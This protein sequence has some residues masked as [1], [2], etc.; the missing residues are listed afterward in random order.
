MAYA[1]RTR[2]TPSNLGQGHSG[3]GGGPRGW[4]PRGLRQLTGGPRWTG[5]KSP[6][7]PRNQTQP[8]LRTQSTAGPTINCPTEN[9]LA[10]RG[11]S[12]DR[13]HG[14]Q[15]GPP[16]LECSWGTMLL[17]NRGPNWQLANMSACWLAN[18]AANLSA[19][20]GA[21]WGSKWFAASWLK[22]P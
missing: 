12:S 7:K 18:P 15:Q 6:Q 19:N 9:G 4:I 11:H 20:C 2:T 22:M 14:H 5:H 16:T 1:N 21:Q 10:I 8:L 17:A 3:R 13:R